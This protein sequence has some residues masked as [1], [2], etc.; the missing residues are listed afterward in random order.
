MVAVEGRVVS[1]SN[2]LLL[3]RVKH[4]QREEENNAKNS[5]VGMY[6]FTY[7]STYTSSCYATQEHKRT[8][9]RRAVIL[10]HSIIPSKSLESVHLAL[11]GSFPSFHI[12]SH[13]TKQNNQLAYYASF[14]QNPASTPILFFFIHYSH[15][16]LHATV[17]IT[18]VL[19]IVEMT[20]VLLQ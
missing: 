1:G 20:T 13:Q 18:N 16:S 14:N 6:L 17:A 10:V 9:V 12:G 15:G 4:K 7:L 19:L 3:Y 5:A 11:F 2:E 8:A